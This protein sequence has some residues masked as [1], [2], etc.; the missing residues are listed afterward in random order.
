MRGLQG[1][2]DIGDNKDNKEE[3]AEEEGEEEGRKKR[4]W[5]GSCM[6]KTKILN[7]LPPLLLINKKS[8]FLESSTN[9]INCFPGK[10]TSTNVVITIFSFFL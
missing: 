10:R 6:Q 5:L 4:I 2:Q 1:G 7:E 9:S 8:D 3:E